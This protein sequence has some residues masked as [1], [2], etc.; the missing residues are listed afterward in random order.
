VIRAPERG[1]EQF[2][3]GR[4]Q[5][6]QL[7][8]AGDLVE[9]DLGRA[10]LGQEPVDLALVDRLDGRL[11]VGLAGQQDANDVRVPGT[12][13][14]QEGRAVH[15]RHPHVGNDDGHRHGG[16]QLQRLGAAVRRVHL[17]PLAQLPPQAVEDGDLVVHQEDRRSVGGHARLRTGGGRHGGLLGDRAGGHSVS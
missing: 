7:D 1:A 11:G 12:D 3:L 4:H 17:E 5:A 13:A 16:Q 14:G 8:C 6:V 15:L 10:R 9:E 2:L